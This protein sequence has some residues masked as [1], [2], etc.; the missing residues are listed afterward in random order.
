MSRGR[1]FVRGDLDG[2]FGLMVDNLV[3]V[4][5]IVALCRGLL[6][7][8]DALIFGRILPGVAVS[9]LVGNLYY[10]W[11]ARRL[12]AATGRDDI[13][14]LPYGI[15]TPSVFAFVFLVMLPVKLAGGDLDPALSAERA[16]QAGLAACFLSGLIE[17]LGA[18]VGPWIR[19]NSP[20]A[21]MLAALSGIALTLI[22]M[23]FALRIFREPLA[24]LIGLGFV[25]AHYMSRKG[26]PFGL[27]AG[28]LAVV[29]GSL[30]A[31]G[32][33]LTPLDLPASASTGLQL[34]IPLLGD[35]IAGFQVEGLVTAASVVLTMGLLNVLGTLQNV[36]SAEAAGDSYP[37]ASTM[38]LNG[39]GTMAASIFGS[40][41][42]TTVY[43]GH[44]GWKAMGARSGY[45]TAN[46]LFWAIVIF[47]GLAIHLARWIPVEAGAA[48]VVWISIVITS[49]AFQAT[50]R[51]HAPAVAL[52]FF[53]SLA[54]WGVFSVLGTLRAVEADLGPAGLA[55]VDALSG[56]ALLGGLHLWS[57]FLFTATLWAGMG[58]HLIERKFKAAAIW[59]TLCA[60]F[61]A[62]GLI[63]GVELTP[64]G[65]VEKL[66]FGAAGWAIPSCY[67]VIALLF[68]VQEHHGGDDDANAEPAGST[69]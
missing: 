33:G 9:L 7:F 47:G 34:P 48:I 26:L 63:H 1:W 58:V 39:S 67:L 69:S 21:A 49:Q 38:V 65:P 55:K 36:E 27:P 8:P 44:P 68:L 46:G 12:A 54:A 32:T 18:T 4:L 60:V 25:L 24:G 66:G 17:A 56:M 57:G 28:L 42:P 5:L 3:Q 20:R 23:D 30:A 41:F 52:G 64:F 35:L 19:R 59:A 11:Q 40:C 13:T 53:P 51:S 22:S 2:F 62:I 6:Q 37:V 29:I 16:W 31:W 43:I 14:A 10:A 45:S 61:S 50:P 15:N